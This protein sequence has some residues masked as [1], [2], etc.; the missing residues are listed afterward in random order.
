MHLYENNLNRWV[1]AVYD[2]EEKVV[3]GLSKLLKYQHNNYYAW[4]FSETRHISPFYSFKIDYYYKITTGKLFVKF[5][6]NLYVFFNDVFNTNGTRK[7]EINR[8]Y[9]KN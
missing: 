5:S 6:K 7:N 9:K 8:I 4:H 1:N 2:V 3:G